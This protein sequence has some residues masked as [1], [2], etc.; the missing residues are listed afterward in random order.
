ML[1]QIQS[2]APHKVMLEKK[3]NDPTLN[4]TFNNYRLADYKDALVHLLGQVVAVSMKT[5]EI[6]GQMPEL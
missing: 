6:I 4:A 5:M 1:V 3:I 2:W